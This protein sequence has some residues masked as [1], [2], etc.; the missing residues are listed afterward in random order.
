M[1]RT[2]TSSE[3]KN[4]WN[5]ANYRRYTV[6]LRMDDDREIIDFIEQQTERKGLI[7]N[8]FREGYQKIKIEGLK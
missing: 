8:I 5:K 2:K 6:N 3:V 4:R 7:T 1:A